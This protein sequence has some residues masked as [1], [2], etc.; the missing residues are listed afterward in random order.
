MTHPPA[1]TVILTQIEGWVG[2]VVRALQAM[3]GD[4]SPW[5]HVAVSLGDGT[6]F[7]AQ[8]GGAVI[9]PWSQYQ[10]RPVALL[11]FVRDEHQA[12]QVVDECRRR[13]GAGYNYTTYFYLAAYR[14]RLPVLTRI[15]RARVERSDKM[16]C[17][18]AADDVH[19][20]H[21]IHIFNDG[22]LP[23]DVT[24]GDFARLMRKH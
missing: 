6:V 7:E 19:R 16:I 17:S 23:F 1:G 8:P 9:T 4:V 10:F 13:V 18:Q 21:G 20:V 11:R 12:R 24:P 2:A 14:L 5:T 15:L 3:N 22:R